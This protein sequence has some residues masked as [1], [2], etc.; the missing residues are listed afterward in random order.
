MAEKTQTEVKTTVVLITQKE[1]DLKAKAEW[2]KN[3]NRGDL[4]ITEDG[5]VYLSRKH[6]VKYADVREMDVFTCKKGK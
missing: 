6:A 4:Y 3:P 1:A 5:N 2:S